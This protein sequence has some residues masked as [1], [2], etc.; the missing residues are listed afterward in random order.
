M[1]IVV[2]LGGNALIRRG[3]PLS[4]QTQ[5]DNLLP[6]ARALA[7][8]LREHSTVITHGNGP[9]V[10][11]LALQSAALVALGQG[12][13]TPLDV[14]GAESEGMVGYLVE[15]ALAN[16]APGLRL[17]TLLTMV[18]VAADDPA[19]ASPSKPI[20]PLL[21][22]EQLPQLQ[23]RSGWQ[24]ARDGAAWRR[25]VPS[26]RPQRVLQMAVI[27]LLV[28]QGVVV[29][30]GGGGGVPV[31]WRNGQHEGIDAVVDKDHASGL[32]ARELNADLLLLLT[33][34]PGVAINF[35]QPSQ[36]WLH[37]VT[38]AVLSTLPLPA[39]SMAPKVQAAVEF[40]QA[41]G[42]RAAIG[43]L[44]AVQALVDGS[45]GTQVRL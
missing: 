4:I 44:D 42:R 7:P 5:R 12:A 1:R 18:E 16:A 31:L 34:V 26:P 33:D 38:T 43:S 41:T 2:A 36:R 45:A 23:A 9:Q 27:R 11:Q 8:V 37:E 25:V 17:A 21:P 20:G 14:L 29:V 30:C 6:A 13:D 15:Q 10:G 19:F 3:Q 40:V 22:V 35:G 24:F 39:G 28:E 32:I